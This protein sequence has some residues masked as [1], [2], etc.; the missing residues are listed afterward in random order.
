MS[1][2]DYKSPNY[3]NLE[4]TCPNCNKLVLHEVLSSNICAYKN[5][6]RYYGYETSKNVEYL[7]NI[8]GTLFNN[9]NNI[10]QNFINKSYD[11]LINAKIGNILFVTRICS[12]CGSR[13]YWEVI[14]KIP[15]DYNC[16][17]YYDDSQWHKEVNL[18]HPIESSI[19]ITANSDM[20]N[21][22]I[23]LFNEAKS[24]F[25]KSPKAAGALLRS[26]LE[27]ILRKAFS[28]KHSDSLLG[29]ILNDKVVREELGEEIIKIC[30]AIKLVGNE[31]S[32][33]ALLI[34]KDE[35]KEEVELLFELI[36][37]VAKEII[38]KPKEK[39]KLLNESNKI[40]QNKNNK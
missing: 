17:L 19:D 33:A 6:T 38:S 14:T 15:D 30:T 35:H 8:D 31:A 24:I 20:D 36:N 37:L 18:I 11:S 40:I 16:Y 25:N 32:H 3:N 26:V 9:E 7:L 22:E 10:I 34:Y 21:D 27:S 39:K 23:S 5:I 4:Y 1:K 28:D 29:K 12:N 13:C 2:I